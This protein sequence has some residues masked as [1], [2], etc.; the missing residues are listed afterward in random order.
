MEW[1][2]YRDYTRMPGDPATAHEQGWVR[3]RP[4]SAFAELFPHCLLTDPYHRQGG[5]ARIGTVLAQA[6]HFVYLPSDASG[7]YSLR[8]HVLRPSFLELVCARALELKI[9]APIRSRAALKEEGLK[10]ISAD[11]LRFAPGRRDWQEM[12]QPL[13]AQTSWQ[14]SEHLQWVTAEGEQGSPGALADLFNYMGNFL[15]ASSRGAGS[16]TRTILTY[17]LEQFEEYD[18]VLKEL[19]VQNKGKRLM[20]MLSRNPGPEFLPVDTPGMA[21]TFAAISNRADW[22]L[23]TDEQREKVAMQHVASIV[24][25]GKFECTR[26]LLRGAA[27]ADMPDVL[28]R[29]SHLV[30]ERS[31]R[32][33]LSSWS[34]F[35]RLEEYLA[36]NKAVFARASARQKTATEKAALLEETAAGL[37]F[38]LK[39]GSGSEAQAHGTG[40]YP[41]DMLPALN[42]I[43]TSHDMVELDDKISAMFKERPLDEF[44]IMHRI[45]ESRHPLLMKLL[46]GHVKRLPILKVFTKIAS[47]RCRW[48][49]WATRVLVCGVAGW[50]DASDREQ[51]FTLPEKLLQQMVE[52]PSKLNFLQQVWF[53]YAAE[54]LHERVPARVSMAEAMADAELR[55]RLR[56]IG[57]RVHWLL[58]CRSVTEGRPAP[59]SFAAIVDGIAKFVRSGAPLDGNRRQRHMALAAKT[60]DTARRE[61]QADYAQWAQA[62]DPGFPLPTTWVPANATCKAMLQASSTRLSKLLDIVDYAPELLAG[63]GR[64]DNNP[65]E[66]HDRHARAV[67][68]TQL[69]D[70]VAHSGAR[71]LCLVGLCA[72]CRRGLWASC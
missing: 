22:N 33:V 18:R 54:V 15:T 62:Q 20:W 17:L 23:G 4:E 60:M 1:V 12:M 9:T 58:G 32:L 6:L 68:A 36:S 2:P 69:R 31:E 66:C 40:G 56:E 10:V 46:L 30:W 37:K 52:D 47:I 29:V 38:A 65:P 14:W 24:H 61:G 39:T 41:K 13:P 25:S 57:D 8:R 70:S 5:V 55:Q 59:D 51:A 7:A 71:T 19:P 28:R 3:V 42:T 67:T 44:E 48:Q 45:T 11:R 16:S 43:I 26:E 63:Q 34:A 50:R 49:Q 64:T 21:D 27:E 53:P 72:Q 35:S